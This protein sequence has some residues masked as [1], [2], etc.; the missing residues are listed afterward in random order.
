MIWNVE[1]REVN[2]LDWMRLAWKPNAGKKWVRENLKRRRENSEFEDIVTIS[3][4]TQ[5]NARNILEL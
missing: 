2:P 3:E 1:T 5:I 4:T